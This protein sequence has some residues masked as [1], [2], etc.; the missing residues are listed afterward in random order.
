M[1]CSIQLQVWIYFVG[2]ADFI[3]LA[4][5]ISKSHRSWYFEW[6]STFSGTKVNNSLTHLLN[7][8]VIDTIICPCS[9]VFN[10]IWRHHASGCTCFHQWNAPIMICWW[11]CYFFTIYILYIHKH[12]DCFLPLLLVVL[13]KCYVLNAL[14][15]ASWPLLSLSPIL[16][17]CASVHASTLHPLLAHHLCYLDVDCVYTIKQCFSTDG[18]QPTGGPWSSFRWAAKSSEITQ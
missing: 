4:Y 10:I 14:L 13:M 9:C 1:L 17:A 18:L 12:C 11:L 15:F 2:Y 5:I 6:N 16:C 7:N 3:R 8:F